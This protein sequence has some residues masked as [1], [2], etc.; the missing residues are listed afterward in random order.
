[1]SKVNLIRCT[2]LTE[3][4]FNK[5][6]KLENNLYY[7]LA[8]DVYVHKDQVNKTL[9]RPSEDCYIEIFK[10]KNGKMDFQIIT[11]KESIHVV[12][13]TIREA[14]YLNF[15]KSSLADEMKIHNNEIDF[16]V[17]ARLDIRS[18]INERNHN[19]TKND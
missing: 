19:M 7:E 11:V 8:K 12:E 15:S 6:Y 16:T 10:D 14:S 4:E 9:N 17:G 5:S 2:F 1:M 13:E 18:L 3:E